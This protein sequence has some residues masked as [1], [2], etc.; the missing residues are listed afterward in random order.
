MIICLKKVSILL[1]MPFHYFLKLRTK[2]KQM[3]DRQEV[4]IHTC[5]G[6]ERCQPKNV[7]KPELPVKS[8]SIPSLGKR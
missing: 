4:P 6:V 7:D 2:T 3:T 5:Y 1:F 8:E